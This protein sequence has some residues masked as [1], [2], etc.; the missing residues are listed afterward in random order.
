MQFSDLNLNK[1]LLQSL[2]ENGF[3]T[4]TTI[5]ANAFAPIM[6]GR[7]V[8]GIAQTGTGKTFAYLLPLLRLWRFS[9]SPNPSILIIVPTRELV[10]QVVEEIEMLTEHM[11]VV[12]GG[13][14]GGAN[15]KRQISLLETG[16]D[17]LVATPGRLLDLLKKGAL[18]AIGIKKLVIDEVD[19]MFNLGF[20]TQLR[21]VLNM[22]PNKMQALLFSA[23]MVDDVEVIIEEYFKGP[24]KI[25]AAPMGT[26]LENIE[27]SSYK[28]PNFY[29]KISLLKCLL[30]DKEKYSKVL[31]FTA[32]KKL[33]NHVAEEIEE[34]YPEEFGVIHSNK[35]QNYRFNV[36]NSFKDGTY[37]FILATDIVARGIDVS[38]VSHVINF[39]AP[40]VPENYIH[41]I[42][43][44]G[45]A[46]K[47]GN[48]VTFVTESDQENM[49]A[50]CS[51]MN[52]EVP[53]LEL[54]EDVVISDE[55]TEAEKPKI[56]MKTI[57]L[58]DTVRREAGPAFH[59]K[60]KKNQT[61]NLTRAE[62]KKYRE[63]NTIIKRKARGKGKRN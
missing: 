21:N 60:S 27:Q 61:V 5:Q 30:D 59:E 3:T 9:K 8:V 45:R 49:D 16:L 40:E 47:K 44:T 12:V 58:K 51:L 42:G 6:S 28:I 24:I 13:A 36:I 35:S 39:D 29:S 10:T 41:R 25:E 17:I 2:D 48:S 34:H 56:I 14:Y 54:P 57:K 37:R 55:L 19:E 7:D 43:R 38:Q 20:R 52:Y 63:I 53:V 1:Q 23:T 50:I 18:K 11:N 15:I 32:T 26:P 33:A 22:L 4:P 62:R 46:D 31:V